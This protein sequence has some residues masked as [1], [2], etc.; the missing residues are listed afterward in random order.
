MSQKKLFIDRWDEPIEISV[1][2]SSVV[3]QAESKPDYP[4]LDDPVAA[5]RRA[6]AAPLGMPPLRE[7]VGPKSKVAIA[8]DDPLKF[9]PKYLAVPVLLEELERAGVQR[10]NITLVSA[11]GTH[12]KPPKEDFKGFYRGQYPVLPDEIVDEFWP[13]RFI[14]HDAHNPDT[15]IKMGTSRLGDLVEH[16]RVLVDSDL[17]IYIGS[18][19]PLIWGGYSGEGAAIGL[20]S[21]RSIYS[22]HK[23]EVIGATD[24]VHSD[25][26]THEFRRHKDAIMDRIEKFIGK[27][28]FYLNGVPDPVGNWAGFFAGHYKEIQEPAWECADRRHLR[29]VAQAD[30]V[31]AGLPHYVWYADTRNPIVNIVGATMILRSWRNKPLL[32]KGGVM[33]LV[34]KC[35]G[36]IDPAKHPSYA[37]AFDL[38][39]KTHSAHSLEQEHFETLYSD[40]NLAD[41]YMRHNAYH[42]VHPIW[43]FDE[44]QYALDH[45]GR[46]IIAT[47]ENPEAV[48]KI[49]AEHAATVETAMER[50]VE[51]VGEDPRILVLPN[52]FSY[53]PM[54]FLVE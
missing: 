52:F 26:R 13:D 43:L 24:S 9:S 49:G 25:P 53:V 23:Y 37:R 5:I 42:P 33:I 8:F 48:A 21:A 12:D 14:N 1:P 15:L 10:Q 31:I 34:S 27:K 45:S 22:H 38:F 28:V 2:Q 50:A 41:K 11:N 44:N 20:A 7:L 40:S 17:T 3:I 18:V 6:L 36:Y 30:I 32:R 19:M 51:L 46:I 47:A 4:A 39:Q 54:V 35:D 16:D 29:G